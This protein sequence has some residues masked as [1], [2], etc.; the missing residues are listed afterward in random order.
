MNKLKFET[1]DSKFGLTQ[2]RGF[3][4][5]TRE[6][7][8]FEFQVLDTILEIVKSEHKELFVSFG[9]IE[10]IYYEKEWFAGGS[11]YIELNS[12]KNIEDVPFLDETELCLELERKHK[13]RG[14]EFAVNSQL[15]LSEY[16][17]NQMD[18]VDE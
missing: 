11:V 18:K 4:W 6:G 17:L 9:Q 2:A 10:R 12:L 5:W 13:S 7:L 3:A 1:D 14:K 16:N 8:M 15:E